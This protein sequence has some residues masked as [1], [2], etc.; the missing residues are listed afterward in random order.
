MRVPKALEQ[1][2]SIYWIRTKAQGPQ[3]KL[4]FTEELLKNSP[5]GDVFALSLNAGMGWN[6][7]QVGLDNYLILSTLGGYRA[8]DGTPIALGYHTG[9]WELGL[10]V[11]SAAEA[12]RDMG[13]IPFAGYCSDPCD[14]RTQGTAGMMDSLAYRNTAAETLGRLIRSLPTRKGIIG[15]ATC[16]KGLPAMMMALA[17]ARD[18]PG[19]LVPGG[20]T[21]P[22]EQGED[23]GVIQS[24]GTRFAHGEVS[25]EEAAALGCSACASPGGGCQF[26]GT[27]A[28]SQVIGEALGMSLPHSALAPSGENVWLELGNSSARALH[29]LHEKGIR[30]GDVLT[31]GSLQNAMAVHAA[32]GGSTNL[33]LHLPA[34]AYNAGL[35]RPT[36]ED[37]SLMNRRVPRIVDVLP[38]G[39]MN[40][41]TVQL[42]LAGGVPEI[43]LR[44]REMGVLHLDCMTA[45]GMSVG[46]NLEWWENSERRKRF[47]DILLEEDGVDSDDVI[48]SPEKAAERGLG[49]TVIFPQGNLA[50][51][52]SVV[53]ATAIDPSLC[54]GGIYHK[55]GIARVFTSEEDAIAAIR[56][57]GPDRLNEDNIIVLLCRG[58]LGAGMPETAQ[59][60]IALKYTKTLKHIAL[61]TDGRF[62][63]FSSGPCIGHVGPEALGGGPIGK[64]HNGDVIEIQIDQ[65]QLTGTINV[66]GKS[67]NGPETWDIERGNEILGQRALREDLHPDSRL[68]DSVR[69]WA[70]L[71]QMGGGTWGG[72]VYDV[73]AI[74]NKLKA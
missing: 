73:D 13:T 69:L 31:D 65:N 41:K 49:S 25:L 15:I 38:N 50:P 16:D 17:E 28:S 48:M 71:Q 35:T 62:S 23:A 19:I 55:R 58:P 14:G 10:L 21:L 47:R 63:G 74:V 56:S 18:F 20:V 9:H 2:D 27:A 24:I 60:T 40:F 45:S 66:I 7:A 8:A 1:P 59:I 42:F 37:W 52:G 32:V 6:P 43:M 5:S 11:K 53:K 57:S 36:V 68:P 34:I 4:P 29:D 70:A 22:P 12:F 30:M 51:Q 72:C 33:L 54:P 39:P 46:E 26:L 67:L 44:L 61:I 3:G 64:V